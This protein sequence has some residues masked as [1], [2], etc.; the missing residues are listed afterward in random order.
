M[1]RRWSRQAFSAIVPNLFFRW[2]L[3]FALV[4]AGLVAG[5]AQPYGLASRPLIGPFLNEV[6]PQSAPGISGAWSTVPAFPNIFFTNAVGLIPV[7]GT[8]RLCVWER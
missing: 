7:P 5:V 2:L 4:S 8:N 1:S 6:M 3:Y